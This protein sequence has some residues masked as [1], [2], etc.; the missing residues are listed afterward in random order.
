MKKLKELKT[1]DFLYL[2]FPSTISIYD[3]KYSEIEVVMLENKTL[4]IFYDIDKWELSCLEITKKNE[5]DSEFVYKTFFNDIIIKTYMDTEFIKE[6]RK[7]KI[8]KVKE[9]LEELINLI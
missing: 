2:Y 1:G 7:Q 9:E 6:K 4:N 3:V 8:E 5:N